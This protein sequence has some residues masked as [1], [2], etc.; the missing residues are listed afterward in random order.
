V[1]FTP[2]RYTLDGLSGTFAEGLLA[3]GALQASGDVLAGYDIFADLTV[4]V[5]DAAPTLSVAT[6]TALAFESLSFQS[7]SFQARGASMDS[8]L[9][10]LDASFTV[11]G[12]AQL[13]L[14]LTSI[15]ASESL[16]VGPW[17]DFL[18][19]GEGISAYEDLRS[20]FFDGDAALEGVV[21]VREGVALTNT[22]ALTGRQGTLL[23]KGALEIEPLSARGFVSGTPFRVELYRAEDSELVEQVLLLKGPLVAPEALSIGR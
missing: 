19:V 9:E 12:E 22:L 13:S 23:A 8:L 5:E 7:E 6:D 21:Q 1:Q 16:D 20:L 14:S 2:G 4:A 15:N 11:N 10:N 17:K 3:G 18:A